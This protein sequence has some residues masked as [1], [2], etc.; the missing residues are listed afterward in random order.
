MKIEQRDYLWQGRTDK[1]SN[2]V[3]AYSFNTSIRYGKPETSIQIVLAIFHQSQPKQNFEESRSVSACGRTPPHTEALD[4]IYTG[5]LAL[6][7]N[8]LFFLK[9]ITGKFG[10]KEGRITQSHD[11]LT[12][13]KSLELFRWRYEY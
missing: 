11:T 6:K 5:L 4:P 8:N 10:R 3:D 7:N 12:R 13:S 1:F 9:E 2:T